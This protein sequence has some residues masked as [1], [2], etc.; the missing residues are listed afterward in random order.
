MRKSPTAITPIIR[1]DI[2]RGN[3]WKL[4]KKEEWSNSILDLFPPDEE[5]A[6]NIRRVKEIIEYTTVT[7]VPKV[8]EWIRA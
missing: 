8:P 1:P 2:V 5:Y 4:K 6:I 3:S 7:K